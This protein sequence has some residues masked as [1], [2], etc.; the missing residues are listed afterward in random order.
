VGVPPISRTC[1][2]VGRKATIAVPTLHAFTSERGFYEDSTTWSPSWT[3]GSG[4]IATSTVDDIATS[5]PAIFSGSLLS[6]RAFRQ[7]VAPSTA[8]YP[9]FTEASYYGLGLLVGNGW[10]LQNPNLNGYAGVLGYLP[11]GKLTVAITTT[12][13]RAASL[14]EE[15]FNQLMFARIAGYLA[16]GHPSPFPP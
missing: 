12:N 15:A 7:M 4:T 2:R 6:R 5:A 16:P 11:Q 8:G 10:R 9:G 14:A 3:I 13:N 1:R